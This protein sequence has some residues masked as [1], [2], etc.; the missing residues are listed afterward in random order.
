MEIIPIIYTTLEI[1]IGLTF[2]TLLISYFYN[3]VKPNNGI[4]S[5]PYK[6][7]PKQPDQEEIIEDHLKP[8]PRPFAD[9]IKLPAEEK[10][11]NVDSKKQPGKISSPQKA[12]KS[13][14]KPKSRNK[15][16][17]ILKNL[18]DNP[19]PEVK[20]QDVKKKTVNEPANSLRGEILDKYVEENNSDMFTLK[21]TK[22]K[23][24]E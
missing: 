24:K 20:I 1:V 5:K 4:H 15:R 14:E 23:P 12:D 2:F 3:K 22:E 11:K 21:V 18:S 17:T 7:N 9:K 8:I 13:S 19:K 6:N 16:L 10:K